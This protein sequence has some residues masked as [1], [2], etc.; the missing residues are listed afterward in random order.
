M[1]PSQNP[2]VVPDLSNKRFLTR[3]DLP[4]TPTLQTAYNASTSPEILTD[5][6]RGAVT[7]KRGSAADTDTVLE[8]MNGSDSVRTSFTGD[9]KMN[10]AQTTTNAMIIG[11]TTGNSRGTNGADVQS[12]RTAVTQVASGANSSAFGSGNTASGTYSAAIG[13][14]NTGSNTSAS[15]IGNGNSA[16]NVAATSVGTSNTVSGSRGTASG[17]SNQVSGNFSTAL[18]GK[19]FVFGNVATASGYRN[20]AS[21]HYSTASGYFN[22]SSGDYSVAIGSS[23]TASVLRAVAIGAGVNNSTASSVEIGGSN[24]TKVRVDAAGRLI[25]LTATSAGS[26]NGTLWNDTTQKTISAFVD[27]MS[28]RLSG[29]IFTQTADKTVAN[30]VTE[31]SIIGTGV[32]TLTLPASFFVAGKTVRITIAGV[33]STVAVTGDTVTVKIKYGSTV[34]VSKATTSLV[35]GGTNLAWEAEVLITCR[36][37]GAS[38]TVQVGGGLTYQIAGAVAVYDEFNN[39]AATSTLNTTTSNLLDITVTHSAADAANSI[40]SLVSS[41]EVLN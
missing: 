40:K 37:T 7:I 25:L 14:S 39:G 27:G 19:N 21:G 6:T 22:T 28:Q 10:I 11:N 1:Q 9:G 3:S 36:T 15:A 18:G 33:Y 17:Y 30:T 13:R 8:I 32:G 4:A 16:S 31:T 41:F 5:A 29:T 38:G 35:T 2:S 34:L 26:I 12:A 20:T 24:A 23:C